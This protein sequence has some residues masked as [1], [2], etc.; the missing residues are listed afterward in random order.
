MRVICAI[1]QKGG[2]ELV[3]RLTGIVGDQAECLLLHVIDT[4]P[5]HDLEDYLRGPLHRRPDH[6][7]PPHG[8]VVKAAEETAGRAAIEEAMAAAQQAGL[9]AETSVKEGK[10]EDIIVQ[11]A[12]D[13]QAAL[14]VIWADE[15]AA[16]HPHIGPAS[17]GQT[18]RFVIDHAPCDVLLLRGAR[19]KSAGTPQDAWNNKKTT[20]ATRSIN[21]A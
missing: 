13:V 14:V 2:P 15:G 18:A 6:G 12:R 16:G 10:P 5:R 4:G 19:N 21:S 20:N 17:V 8:A 3:K 1:G 9:K 11:V 7:E